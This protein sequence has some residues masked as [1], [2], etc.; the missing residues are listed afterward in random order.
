MTSAT[1]ESDAEARAAANLRGIA[2]MLVTGLVFVIFTGII[3]HVGSV[4]QMDPMQAAFIRYAFGLCIMAPVFWRLRAKGMLTR[5]LP[6]H[7]VRGV[8]PHR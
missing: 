2:W 4:M 5:R 6:L 7:A 3:R 8:P 1:N